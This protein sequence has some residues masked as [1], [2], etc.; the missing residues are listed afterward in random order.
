MSFRLGYGTNG[1]A[2][3]RLCDALSIIAELGYSA[4]A[5]TLDHQHLDPYAP[6]LPARVDAVAGQLSRLGLRVVVET[7]ARYLLDPR[8]KHHPTLISDGQP[9]RLDLLRRALRIAADL[10]AD[11]VSFFS[12]SVPAGLPPEQAWHR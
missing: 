6:D 5:L 9:A 7:G 3:H 8:R 11:C 1:F 2:N 12:G 10:G 4:V